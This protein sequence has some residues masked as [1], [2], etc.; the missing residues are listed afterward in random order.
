MSESRTLILDE[1][2]KLRLWELGSNSE[3]PVMTI[4]E[5]QA[6]LPEALSIEEVDHVGG[7]LVS[8]VEKHHPSRDN[9]SRG[10]KIEKDALFAIGSAAIMSEDYVTAR[11]VITQLRKDK[12]S[13]N[14]LIGAGILWLELRYH[15]R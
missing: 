6:L 5:T 9:I 15:S 14:R 2:T 12:L 4:E 7:N 10:R 1:V 3:R 8:F 11:S 13:L